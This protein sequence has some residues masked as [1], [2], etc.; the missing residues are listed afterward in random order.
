MFATGSSRTSSSRKTRRGG[1]FGL[2]L[3]PELRGASGFG[4]SGGGQ[5]S[6]RRSA[7]C[8]A[9]HMPSR[10]SASTSAASSMRRCTS[11][12]RSSCAVLAAASS[13]CGAWSMPPPLRLASLEQS[14][15]SRDRSRLLSVSRGHPVPRRWAHDGTVRGGESVPARSIQVLGFA[16]RAPTWVSANMQICPKPDDRERSQTAPDAEPGQRA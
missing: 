7:R 5:G 1:P 9:R 3:S 11:A 14:G 10:V 16:M 13:G 8:F 2:S 6:P 12:R 4:G 15:G